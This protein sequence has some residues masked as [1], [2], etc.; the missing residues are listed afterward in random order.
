MIYPLNK[1]GISQ[2]EAM[3]RKRVLLL[4]E[5][6]AE[7]AMDYLLHFG[8]HSFL[9]SGPNAKNGPG[10]SA[11]YAANWNCSVGS[12]DRSV[13]TPERDPFNEKAEAYLGDL[14]EKEEMSEGF[15]DKAKFGEQLFV[16]NS[17]YYG[18]WLNDGGVEFLSHNTDSNPNRFVELCNA[19]L[20][21]KL[22]DLIREIKE[23][24]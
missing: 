19:Y 22:K 20:N 16:T 9:G 7:A 2:I 23:I 21:D 13:I 14:Y 11:Y 17:V 5:K 24:K 4:Q 6:L 12:I 10:W 15:F 8:Y 18:K 1:K 3:C